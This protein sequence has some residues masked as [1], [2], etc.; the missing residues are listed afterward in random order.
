MDALRLSR[1]MCLLSIVQLTDCQSTVYNEFHSTANQNNLVL[2]KMVGLKLNELRQ[3][4]SQQQS[5][6]IAGL[7]EQLRDEVTAFMVG[8]V[9]TI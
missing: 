4:L 7:S 1:L 6:L 9:A 3:E 5:Q 2:E 8:S